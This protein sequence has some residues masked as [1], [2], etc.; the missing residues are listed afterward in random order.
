MTLIEL[1]M[2]LQDNFN[3]V[4]YGNEPG[5]EISRRDNGHDVDEMYADCEVTDIYP[6]GEFELSV[7]IDDEI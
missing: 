1:S 6:S 5:V 2:V 3:V 4:I 7:C